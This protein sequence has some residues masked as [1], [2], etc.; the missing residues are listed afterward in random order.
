MHPLLLAFLSFPPLVASPTCTTSPVECAL[1]AVIDKYQSQGVLS[2]SLVVEREGKRYGWGFGLADDFTEEKNEPNTIFA[3]ASLSKSFVSASILRLK[4]QGKLKLEDTLESYLPE[5][6]RRNLT[7]RDGTEVTLFHLLTH[8]S[9]IHEAY[10]SPAIDDN[11]DRVS[12]TFQDFLKVVKNKRLKFNPGSRFDYS[13]TGYLMLGEVIRRITGGSYTSFL[14]Q[15]FLS[16]LPLTSTTVG[17]PQSPGMLVARP[18]L[19]H[20]SGREDERDKLGLGPYAASDVYTDTNIYTSADNLAQWAETITSG[21]VLSADST[22]QMLTPHLQEYGFGWDVYSDDQG[23]KADEHSGQYRVY[24]SWMRRYPHEDVTMA[25][26]S[27]QQTEEK[28]LEAFVEEI[29]QAAL[30]GL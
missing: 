15:N 20:G 16:P 28:T 8:T 6:P 21:E 11:I 7:G 19:K 26:V 17:P 2:G 30:T 25:Y 1:Q 12:L 3:I 13:N 23:R 10:D 29:C 24:Q 9:G 22:N 4:D 5:Y 18:Y 27:N 14:T